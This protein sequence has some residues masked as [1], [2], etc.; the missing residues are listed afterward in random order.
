MADLT[1]TLESER[2]G[3]SNHLAATANFEDQAETKA[4]IDEEMNDA[5]DAIAV[6]ENELDRKDAQVRELLIKLTMLCSSESD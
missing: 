1:P 5:T 4:E 3:H 2:E 6:L